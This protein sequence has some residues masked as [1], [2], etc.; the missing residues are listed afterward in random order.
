MSKTTTANWPAFI[1]VVSRA[2]LWAAIITAIRETPEPDQPCP[3]PIESRP[4]PPVTP[5]PVLPEPKARDSAS[6]H[7]AKRRGEWNAWR[8]GPAARTDEIQSIY[9][10]LILRGVIRSNGE[11]VSESG[12]G[13][14]RRWWQ[15]RGRRI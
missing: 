5:T 12:G 8:H 6:E 11:L 4:T 13:R 1:L 7:T 10:Q 15:R 9:E 3:S 14:R 2:V